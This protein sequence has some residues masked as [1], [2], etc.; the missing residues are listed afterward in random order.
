M[1]DQ[2]LSKLVVLL[3]WFALPAS[4]M[5]HNQSYQFL[6]LGNHSGDMQVEHLDDGTHQVHFN[7]SD[8]GRGPDLTE[9]YR[10]D[11]NGVLT[12]LTVSGNSYMGSDVDE[13]LTLADGNYQWRNTAE[14][15]TS[16]VP[17]F[18]AAMNGTPYQLA[19]MAR[20]LLAAPDQRL[21]L[22]PSGEA[23][24]ERAGSVTVGKIGAQKSVSLYAVYGLGFG[25]SYL[26]LNEDQSLFGFTWGWAALLPEAYGEDLEALQNFADAAEKANLAKIAKKSANKLDGLTI[27]HNMRLFDPETLAVHEGRAVWIENGRISAVTEASPELPRDA[28]YINGQ[29]MLLMPGLWDM[30][31]HVSS[32]QGV[33]HVAAGITNLRDMANDH[34]QLSST[35]TAFD[36]GQVVGPRVV[37][38]GFMDQKGEFA[39]PSKILAGN[40]DEALDFVRWYDEE[41]YQQIK[42]YSSIDPEWVAPIARE[43]HSLGLRISGHIPS[44]MTTEAAVRDGYDEIQHINMVF[45]NF[46]AGPEDDTRTPV[47]FKLIADHAG[48]LDLDSDEVNDFIALL[49]E[50]KVVVDPTVTIFESMLTHRSGS[51]NNAY[52]AVA[53]QL[54]ANVRRGLLSNDFQ[55]TDDT[56]PTYAKGFQALL[57]MIRRLHEAGVRIVPG[58]DAMAGFTLQRE[59]ENYVAAGIPAPEVLR[60]ATLQSAQ[61]A[62]REHELGSIQPGKKADLIFINGN[63]LENISDIREV[64]MVIKDDTLYHTGELYRAIGVNRFQDIQA[65]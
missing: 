34:D 10:L 1:N 32:D 59:L 17:G 12:E 58:T 44:F 9:L 55:I 14:S 11:E 26:W 5:A 35:I 19:V 37:R 45:L 51:I 62:E 41:G 47:R 28:R 29:E 6:M 46:L 65:P 60:I 56:A 2:S 16:S 31:G 24:I 40:L 43:A 64:R 57:E 63:P 30:H 54:P 48:A 3:A 18:Y 39:G 7:F 42:L 33:L 8:R 13:T 61:I 53:D 4:A 50:R 15:G 38:A 25:P 27:V 21:A 20:A 52:A 36:S 23:R 22:L 49:A